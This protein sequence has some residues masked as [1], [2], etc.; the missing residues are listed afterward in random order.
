MTTC[1]QG[2]AIPQLAKFCPL[3]GS[4][5]QPSDRSCPNG[6]SVSGDWQFCPICSTSIGPPSEVGASAGEMA[7]TLSA[8]NPA[9]PAA[10]T[11]VGIE[12]PGADS[13]STSKASRRVRRPVLLL[14]GVVLVVLFGGGTVAALSLTASSG[15]STQK[16]GA[17][18]VAWF[19]TT[20]MRDVSK[21]V[22]DEYS[23]SVATTPAD[24]IAHCEAMGTDATAASQTIPP[25]PSKYRRLWAVAMTKYLGAGAL[26]AIGLRSG[27]DT[28]WIPVMTGYLRNA[29]AD[30]NTIAGWIG[31]EMPFSS[32]G[33]VSSPASSTTV[34]PSVP[35]SPTTTSPPVS[36]PTSSVPMSTAPSAAQQVWTWWQSVAEPAVRTLQADYRALQQALTAAQQSGTNSQL[37]SVCSQGESDANAV[38]SGNV[39]DGDAGGGQGLSGYWMFYDEDIYQANQWCIE[40]ISDNNYQDNNSHDMYEASYNNNDS[41]T[42]LAQVE[43]IVTQITGQQATTPQ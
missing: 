40:G 25:F 4:A 32:H 8:T 42:Q 11:L 24:G 28:S 38:D 31:V 23:A 13:R 35:A 10:E 20:G 27:G 21:V 16:A 12:Q 29:E 30:I 15:P 1:L 19:K 5:A 6:H 43:Q 18:S 3:C 41:Q 22:L 37:Q 39:P 9:T 26:C 36:T 17:R 14:I 34:P 33:N 2:H 7:K